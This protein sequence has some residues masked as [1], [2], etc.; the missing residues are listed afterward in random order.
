[1]NDDNDTPIRITTEEANAAPVDDQLQPIAA[2]P[3]LAASAEPS[4]Y[5]TSVPHRN[6][7]TWIIVTLLA[8]VGCALAVMFVLSR[9]HDGSTDPRGQDSSI[10]PT[11]VRSV[12]A[13][14]T[15]DQLSL[16]SPQIFGMWRESDGVLGEDRSSWT[17]SACVLQKN[18]DGVLWL[19]TNDHCLGLGA[20]AQAD[21]VTDGVPDVTSYALQV[22]FPSGETRPVLRI[23]RRVGDIDLAI[24]EIDGSGLTE[25]RDYQFLPVLDDV[26]LLS[27][28]D[29]V[30][31]V[32]SPH[33]LFGTQT[34]G[35][36]SA[37]RSSIP[38]SQRCV[39]IQTD[40]AI[41]PGNSGGPLFLESAGRYA[42]IG[43]NTQR[44]MDPNTGGQAPGIGFAIHVSEVLNSEYAWYEAN[45]SG[46][47]RAI[48]EALGIR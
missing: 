7:S 1:M 39:T 3:E 10:D 45:T 21:S 16:A 34:F 2:Y 44:A 9:G 43:V 41:N 11:I 8:L 33:G 27:P 13:G 20:L 46:V 4:A 6:R 18:S 24:I 22:A 48:K 37:L 14:L 30:V 19:V 31:A 25:G 17:G 26:T 35:H 47:D 40:A 38:G 5:A 23:A 32:G 28:G 15:R 12:D 29:R 42:W 36:V